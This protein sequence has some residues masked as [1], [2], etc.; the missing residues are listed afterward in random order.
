[1][2]ALPIADEV[3]LPDAAALRL[4]FDAIA[5]ANT[6]SPALAECMRGAG[7]AREHL[8]GACAVRLIG[9]EP[10]LPECLVRV[11]SEAALEAGVSAEDMTMLV[12]ARAPGA[13]RALQKMSGELTRT[14]PPA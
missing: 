8:E 12:N 7:W 2:N 9:D 5:H 1:M 3:A 4:L 6:R 14:V 13:E 11:V 10:G